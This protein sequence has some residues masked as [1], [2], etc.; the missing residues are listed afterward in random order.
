MHEEPREFVRVNRRLDLATIG[1]VGFDLDHTL[2]LYD[3]RAVNSLAAVAARRL[4]VERLDYP[5]WLLEN[6]PPM[7]MPAAAR[8]IAA[9]LDHGAIVKLAADRRVLCARHSARWLDVAALGTH[10]P[11]SVSSDRGWVYDVQSPFELP[12]LW[13]LEEIETQL[14]ASPMARATRCM[15]IRRMLD[16]AH[17]NGELKMRLRED[18]D[19]FVRSID[20]VT[21]GLELWAAAGK[22]LFVV[23]NSEPD[24]APAVLERAVGSSW[25]TLFRVVVTGAHKPAFFDASSPHARPHTRIDAVVSQGGHARDVERSLGVPAHRILFVG[26][27]PRSDILAASAHG[28]RTALVAPELGTDAAEH[29]DGWGGPLIHDASTT[30]LG[31]VVREHA[32]LSCENAGRLL[33]RDPFA[34]LESAPASPETP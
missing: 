16:T 5:G 6:T 14:P 22:Q 10:Y 28:W 27:N 13:L 3:D 17:T 11:A 19:R 30:W 23:T 24:F 34:H 21:P 7:E 9:D 33:S 26:D 29:G 1:A 18:L 8:T 15:D 25:R 2:A 31:R 20:G 12:V 32:D 4:L